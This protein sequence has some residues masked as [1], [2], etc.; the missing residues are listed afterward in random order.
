MMRNVRLIMGRRLISVLMVVVVFCGCFGGSG[1][2]AVVKDDSEWFDGVIHGFWGEKMQSPDGELEG[3]VNLGRRPTI[4]QMWGEWSSSQQSLEG[5]IRCVFR[6]RIL[7]GSISVDENQRL[8]AFVGF[9][10]WDD[11]MF[12][13][14][15][16]GRNLPFQYIW[17]EM[18]ASFLPPLNGEYGVGVKTMHL[19]DESRLEQLTPDPDDTRELMM[20]V[21]YPTLRNLS[22]PEVEYMD[23]PT[24][25]WLMGRSPVP[26][27][28]IPDHAYEFVNPHGRE[29]VGVADSEP[30]Y[31]V[32]LFSPGYDGVYQIYTS[33]IEDMVSHGFIV[34]SM[35]H[36]YVSGITVFPDGRQVYV[37][38]NSTGDVGIRTVVDD[39]KFVLD[40]LEEVNSTDPLLQGCL[41]LSLVGMY[42]HSFG[43][44]A[45]SI[46]CSEDDRF[47][48][49]LTLDG[50]FYLDYLSEGIDKP[51]LMQIAENRFNDGNVQE[52]WALLSGES[53]KVEVLGA[54]HS[55]F[56]DVGLLLNHLV[57]LVPPRLLGFGS[58]EPKVHVNISRLYAQVFFEVYLKGRS[59][60]DLLMLS[61]VFDD[62]VV[63]WK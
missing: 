7:L 16:F 5:T 61:S 50:V 51:F 6:E 39:A 44:A 60:D 8:H 10:S 43:G 32:V 54:T 62:V 14:S 36:P 56:T 47:D 24:F 28:T 31:P 45:T 15:L 9:I 26:L 25:A 20:Q 41:D 4:G 55:G 1:A 59:V 42:G 3:Y 27:F 17:G 11:S 22:E 38:S 48:C 52:M 34:V 2:G 37:S 58:I 12:S 30:L 53:F 18:D 63:E 33:L 35:N 23:E 29:G 19:I 57:P 40:V 21:W 49:G 13:A 46:C